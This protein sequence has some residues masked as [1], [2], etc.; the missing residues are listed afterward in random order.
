MVLTPANLSEEEEESEDLE[1]VFMKIV[2]DPTSTISI[3]IIDGITFSIT[4]LGT[5]AFSNIPTVLLFK[6]TASI[7]NIKI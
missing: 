1:V 2:P 5:G 3:L 7:F 6:F 4:A